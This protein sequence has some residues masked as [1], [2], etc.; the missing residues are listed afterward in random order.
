MIHICDNCL[1]TFK[2]TQ[3]LNQ[4]KNR[5]NKCKPKSTEKISPFLTDH[6]TN[7]EEYVEITSDKK[8]DNETKD[9]KN[10][11]NILSLNSIDNLSLL[12]LAEIINNHKKNLQEKQKLESTLVILKKQI[13]RLNEENFDLKHKII[14]VNNFI[15]NFINN[16]KNLIITP[17]S[18]NKSRENKP[19]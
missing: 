5:K 9:F 14:I 8:E 18:L 4:H 13:D 3:H 15:N 2:T 10:N 17:N 16:Y 1:K 6:E 12:N 11:D 7:I 19:V